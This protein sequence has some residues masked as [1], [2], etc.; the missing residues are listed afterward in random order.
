MDNP[1][2]KE[3]VQVFE[4][5]YQAIISSLPKRFHDIPYLREASQTLFQPLTPLALGGKRVRPYFIALGADKI[6]KSILDAGVA[7]EL[8]HVFALIHDDIIDGAESRRGVPTAHIAFEKHIP[9][10]GSAGAILLGDYLLAYANEI[11]QEDHKQLMP[12]FTKLQC[13]LCLGQ[14]YEVSH[15]GNAGSKEVAEQISLFK[16]VQ[17]TFQYP[18]QAGLILA[19]GN[20]HCLDDYAYSTGLAF[21]MKD[22]WLDINDDTATGKDKNLDIQNE[23]PNIVQITLKK[24]NN[25]INETKKVIEKELAGYRQKAHLA[26]TAAPLSARQKSALEDVLVFC[27]TI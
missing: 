15:W 2:Y 6:D 23:V 19:A 14:F 9:N 21:Q 17:Y 4:P 27:T 26:L 13:Q 25:D 20:P 8:L 24:H 18:L 7:F 11:M 10:R 12:L 1:F 16:S 3:F 5:Y 22:D